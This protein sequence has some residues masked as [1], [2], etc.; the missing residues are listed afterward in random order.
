[1]AAVHSESTTLQ[2]RGRAR[3]FP[4]IS[5]RLRSDC[6]YAIVGD[7]I[8]SAMIMS[9]V[10]HIVL[11]AQIMHITVAY[12]MENNTGEVITIRIERN[13]ANAVREAPIH[14]HTIWYG[15]STL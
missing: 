7:S 1:M 13:N 15:S 4:L 11:N 2:N 12:V 6:N 14:A 10:G 5:Y 3:T 8:R 9:Y